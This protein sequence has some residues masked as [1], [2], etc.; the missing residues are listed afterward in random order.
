M[1]LTAAQTKQKEIVKS[2]IKQIKT[3]TG[4]SADEKLFFAVIAQT[5]R[6]LVDVRKAYRR[7]AVFFFN[8]SNFMFMFYAESLDLNPR[9]V[10]KLLVKLNLLET[11]ASDQ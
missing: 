10:I 6:D 9:W 8:E 5:I 2:V 11:K 7:E 4:D 1:K 3:Q